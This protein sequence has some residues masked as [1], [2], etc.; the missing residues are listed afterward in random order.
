MNKKNCR[1]GKM[2]RLTIG[3]FAYAVG[4]STDTVRFYE[5]CGLLPLP[6]RTAANYR[7]YPE[8]DILRLKFIKRAKA[9]GFTLNEIKEL[10]AL[11]HDPRAT[12]EEVKLLPE[13]KI[14]DIKSRI[15]DLQ[16]IQATLEHLAGTCDGHGP[17]DDCPILAAMDT[18]GE[19]E[20]NHVG[21]D[22]HCRKTGS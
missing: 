21:Q 17:A 16:Q 2:A 6:A 20:C 9:L 1:E 22:D 3:K 8:K 5:R 19:A 10:L 4:V 15:A 13:V 12:K 18:E 14:M 7:L 11:H